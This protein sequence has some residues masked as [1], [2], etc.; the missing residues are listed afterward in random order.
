[1]FQR[2]VFGFAL[3]GCL[4]LWSLLH[5][6]SAQT[7]F[8]WACQ[9]STASYNPA[10]VGCAPWTYNSSNEA[11]TITR[12]SVGTY[13]VDFAGLG[14][15]SIS[16]PGTYGGNVQITAAYGGTTICASNGWN[17]TGAD[18]IAYVHCFN[19]T[20]GAA[21]DAEFNILVGFFGQLPIV[22]Q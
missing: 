8:S 19:S 14:R 21:A 4:G 16:G 3:L 7:G 2:F 13:T 15:T 11:V 10:S 12:T 1:M 6:A 17:S 20:N 5:T 18:F 9:Q 22:I